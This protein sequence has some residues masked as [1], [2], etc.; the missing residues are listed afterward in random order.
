MLLS[1]FVK[2][3]INLYAGLVGSKGRPLQATFY[4]EPEPD[5]K[6]FRPYMPAPPG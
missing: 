6:G 3:N 4:A 1:L 2:K 5:L